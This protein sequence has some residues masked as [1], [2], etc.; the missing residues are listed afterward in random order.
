MAAV[1]LACRTGAQNSAQLLVA[2]GSAPQVVERGPNHTVHQRLIAITNLQGQ[3]SGW[4]T[5]RYTE[6]QNGLN[7]AVSGTYVPS[8][9]DVQIT[10]TGAAATNG[11]YSVNFNANLN[12]G[13]S[14]DLTLPQ[15]QH[16][17]CNILSL[18]YGD[19][20]TGS[21]AVIAVVQ[22]SIGQIAGSGRVIYTNAFDRATASV[23]Y[24]Y[25][26][27]G[28]RQD[29][30]LERQ[31]PSPAAWGLSP[32]TSVLQ[33]ISEF[34]DAP[35]A[36]VQQQRMADGSL[37][38]TLINFGTMGIGRGGALLLGSGSAGLGPVAVRKHW[39]VLDSG[40]TLLVE[41]IKYSAIAAAIGSLPAALAPSGTNQQS[42]ATP[43]LRTASAHLQVPAARLAGRQG[44]QMKVAAAPLPKQGFLI[45]YNVLWA[46]NVWDSFTFQKGETY[47]IAGPVTIN[48]VNI[49]GGATLKFPS[50]GGTYQ[51][52]V[53]MDPYTMECSGAE[54]FA[55]T[56]NCF[57]GPWNWAVITAS[58]DNSIGAVI[59]GSSGGPSGLY[60]SPALYL[61]QS[62]SLQYLRFVYAAQGV[63][64]AGSCGELDLTNVEFLACAEPIFVL[65]GAV[66]VNAYNVLAQGFDAF[67]GVW[68]GGCLYGSELEHLTADQGNDF[69][70]GAY[71]P[72]HVVN[73][74]LTSLANAPDP[75][76]V[77]LDPSTRVL[78]FSPYVQSVSGGCYL[79]P[80][81]PY[82][83]AGTTGISPSLLGSLARKTTQPPETLTY[84]VT[85][86]TTLGPSLQVAR[87]NQG[88]GPDLGYHYDPIDYALT[89]SNLVISNATLTL[90]NGVVLAG[91]L[92]YGLQLVGG[93]RLV[94]QGSAT[95]LNHLVLGYGA[96]QLPWPLI[97]VTPDPNCQVQLS[98]T[99]LD[100][101]PSPTALFASTS[102]PPASLQMSHCQVQGGAINISGHV[103]G[104]GP[105]V[106]LTNNL[107]VRC[108]VSLTDSTG[109]GQSWNSLG[110]ALYN[111]LFYGGSATLS[112][113]FNGA[114]S[115]TWSIH[116]NFF[117]QSAVSG[118]AGAGTVVYDHNGYVTGY[119][120]LAPG[121]PSDVVVGDP[122]F[123]P[124]PLGLFYHPGASQFTDVGSR[125]A[126]SAGLYHFTIQV[127]QAIEGNTVVDLGF[128]YVAVDGQG[129]PLDSDGDGVPDYVEDRNGNG[130]ATDDPTSWLV[131]DSPNGL[132]PGRGLQ[133]FTP[134]K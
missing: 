132:A 74:L 101:P 119:S 15:G 100:F 26:R 25:A 89:G 40:R 91:Y 131:Y 56:V 106:M 36:Q 69:C 14:V 108:S 78:G 99:E 86:D 10:S 17:R 95:V 123:Q 59:D 84:P 83:H 133:V 63:V 97:S 4:R 58:D 109:T 22:D 37:D 102:S 19:P 55:G 61:E 75:G 12:S 128:H 35:V 47:F 30:L 92:G 21:N 107:F 82:R 81:S 70:Y 118:G 73:S 80:D 32:E 23:I 60:A 38:D 67:M 71:Y 42:S 2:T 27:S 126:P 51:R 104:F 45:D 53:V 65:G 96:Q 29:V 6:M 1:C 66:T 13:G 85:V 87:D 48:T 116:D 117:C 54:I 46:W 24:T 105:Q 57:T 41:E 18:N 31:L 7:Y 8:S 110:V 44:A 93:G 134:L 113:G 33:V 122:G 130:I 76:S 98:F 28:F 16:L 77:T 9:V 34:V 121:Q 103:T 64:P 50:F 3:V 52:G 111:N 88:P 72:P 90:T 49:E 115:Q 43:V 5:N 112:H 11:Q 120:Q 125:T 39:L 68:S 94:S 20:S 129:N 62:S 124:G 114:G 127:D 79:A